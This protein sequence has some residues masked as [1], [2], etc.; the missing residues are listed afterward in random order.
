MRVGNKGM[1]N[2]NVGSGEKQIH[3]RLSDENYNRDKSSII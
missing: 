1:E 3:K 2:V